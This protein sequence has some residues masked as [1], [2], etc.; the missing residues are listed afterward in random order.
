[1]NKKILPAAGI[2]IV[3]II[4][5]AINELTEL[6]FIKDYALILI[7]AG[8]LLGVWLTKLSVKSKEK[9]D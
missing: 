6:T 9:N 4:L 3:A 8:M 7:I 5:I 2:I 1:M